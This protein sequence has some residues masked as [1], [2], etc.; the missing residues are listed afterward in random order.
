M[1]WMPKVL[2]EELKERIQKRG[3]ELGVP[4]LYDMIADE[5]VGVSEEEIMP[6][7][8]KVGHPA[9]SMDPLVG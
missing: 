9:L 7:L 5:T 8:E 6:F 2:K 1:V 4:D 3:A